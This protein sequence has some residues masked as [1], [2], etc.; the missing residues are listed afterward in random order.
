MVL[1][2]EVHKLM[3]LVGGNQS[4]QKMKTGQHQILNMEVLNFDSSE[5]HSQIVKLDREYINR[6][7]FGVATLNDNI[8][9][10]LGGKQDDGNRMASTIQIKINQQKDQFRV[11]SIIN[12]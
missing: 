5:V 6:V 11:E 3:Y 2:Q 7:K 8:L 4:P 1:K 10:I 9:F 12:E